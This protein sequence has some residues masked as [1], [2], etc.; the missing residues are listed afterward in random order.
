MAS[1]RVAWVVGVSA[2]F[3]AF[4]ARAQSNDELARA[5][6][7]FEAGRALYKLER[8]SEAAREF[9]AG[10][11][12]AQKPQFLIN[13]GQCYRNLKDFAS[14]RDMYKKYL[15]LT[16]PDDPE[17]AQ[18]VSLL[19]EVEKQLKEHP[20]PPPVFVPPPTGPPPPSAAPSPPPSTLTTRAP[21]TTTVVVTS[22]PP[23]KPFIQRHW[24]IFPAGAVVITGL[25]V[26]LYFGLKPADCPSSA[27]LGCV[28]VPGK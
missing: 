18:V 1:R 13:L 9:M 25:A 19:A 15:A 17:R 21:A 11:E 26:G 5:R 10:Y 6:T 22:P 24:W 2:V 12:L 4:A 8:Y 14:A 3:V 20:T 27:T 23:R 16:P 7:H 28:T